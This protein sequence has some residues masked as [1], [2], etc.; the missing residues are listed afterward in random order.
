[1]KINKK[2]FAGGLALLLTLGLTACSNAKQDGGDGKNGGAA[3]DELAPEFTYVAKYATIPQDFETNNLTFGGKVAYSVHYSGYDYFN[4]YA[5]GDEDSAEEPMTFSPSRNFLKYQLNG[6]NIEGGEVFASIPNGVD[7]YSACADDAGNLYYVGA[8]R[9]ETPGEDATDADW[10]LYYNDA[11]QKTEYHL[12]KLDAQGNQVYDL[13]FTEMTRTLDYFYVSRMA[14]DAQGRVYLASSDSKVLLFGADGYYAGIAETDQQSWISNMGTAKDGKVYASYM[15]YDANSS[16]MVL[17]EIDFDG[18]KVGKTYQNFPNAYGNASMV[19][20]LEQDIL[21]SDDSALYEYSLEKEETTKVLTWLDCDIDG[22]GVNNIVT[23]DGKY[24]VLLRDWNMDATEFA[25]LE[26]MKT[27]DVVKREKIVVGT[28]YQDSSLSE[29]IIKFNKS[30][31]QYRITLKTYLD[32]N[33]WTETSYQDAITA[34]TNDILAGTGPDILELST[35]DIDNLASKGVLDDLSP[36]L[37]KSSKLNKSDF[38]DSVLKAGTKN[39]K[40]VSLSAGFSLSTIVGKTSVVGSKQGWTVADLIKLQKAYP[41]SELLEYETKESILQA[42]LMLN[43]THFLDTANHT[44]NFDNQEFKDLL[45]F[46]NIFPKEYDYDAPRRLTPYLLKDNSLLL[47]TIYLSDFDSVQ[48]ELAYF[49]GE[50]YTMVGYPTYDGGNGCVL[51]L[52]DQYGINAKSQHK[53]AAWAFLEEMISRDPMESKYSYYGFSSIKKYYEAQKKDALEVRYVYD[54]NGEILKDENGEPV[55]EQR[56][57]GYTMMGDDGEEW[58]YDYKPITKADVDLVDQLLAGAT[59]I[60]YNVNQELNQIIM[61]EAGSYFD[62]SK[63]LDEV[64][65]VI[66]NRVNLYMKENQ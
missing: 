54:E 55:I 4:Y 19:K 48:G 36:Y 47:A 33:N 23:A 8:I 10:E 44:C 59:P 17:A 50:P 63:S 1:M 25:E 57:G 51:Y 38:H 41:N 13:D 42:I 66:Q 28:I 46:A 35:L 15:R 3:V 40:L 16:S 52:R 53:E 26:K 49:D 18:K 29:E 65:N 34:L 30:N 62:G 45:A 64:V 43:K 5:E 22:N 31:E 2:W 27:E 21:I 9:P 58:S 12:I 11:D 6:G 7:V 37:E 24:Y 61:E 14:V 32:E 60:D 20:G 56:Y 39:G